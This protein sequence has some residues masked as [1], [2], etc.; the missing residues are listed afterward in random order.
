MKPIEALDCE[1]YNGFGEPSELIVFSIVAPATQRNKSFKA[2]CKAH[3]RSV[4][5]ELPHRSVRSLRSGLC[6]S[7]KFVE[8]WRIREARRRSIADSLNKNIPVARVTKKASDPFRLGPER[9]QFR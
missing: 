3:H 1:V 4:F 2:E 8:P 9:I 6:Q 7:G 5:G